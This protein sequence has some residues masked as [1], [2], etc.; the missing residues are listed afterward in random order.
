MTKYTYTLFVFMILRT[1]IAN[2]T[3]T[4]FPYTTLFRSLCGA[5]A[6]N[7]YLGQP[8]EAIVNRHRNGGGHLFGGDGVFRPWHVINVVEPKPL[9]IPF[10]GTKNRLSE[11]FDSHRVGIVVQKIAAPHGFADLLAEALAE[12]KADIMYRVDRNNFYQN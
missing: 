7:S 2:R 8:D 9:T 4:L 1:P 10:L 11:K 6:V 3:D 12:Q 5:A